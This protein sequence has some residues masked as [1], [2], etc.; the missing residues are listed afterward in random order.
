MKN[1]VL[2]PKQIPPPI[3][4][5]VTYGTSIGLDESDG[6][7]F[8]DHHETRGWQLSGRIPMRNWQSA[9]RTWKRNK[10]RFSGCF[11]GNNPAHLAGMEPGERSNPGE[12]PPSLGDE[13][14]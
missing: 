12:Q 3:E 10:A 13:F 14:A 9:M 1:Q 4:W 11:G 7:E 2:N 8:F 6:E 5:C